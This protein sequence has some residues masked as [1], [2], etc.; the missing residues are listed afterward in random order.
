MEFSERAFFLKAFQGSCLTFVISRGSDLTP[1]ALTVLLQVIREVVTGRAD[2]EG[3]R[4]LLLFEDL[5]AVCQPLESLFL[6]LAPHLSR[7]RV[8]NP[9][10]VPPALWQARERGGLV[11]IG[12]QAE[13]LQQFE[14]NIL[15]F[16]LVLRMSRLVWLD[17]AGG[18][19]DG[20]GRT[21]GFLSRSRLSEKVRE[22]RCGRHRLLQLFQSLLAGG[23]TAISLCRVAELDQELFTYQGMGSFFSCRPYCRVRRLGLDDFEH[24]VALIR[25]GEQE[26]F[27]LP[28]S[29][30]ALA[31]LLA[32]SYG[33]FILEG[34]LAGLCALETVPYQTDRAGEIVSLYT[35]T[36]FQG[37]GI[38]GQLLGHM[39]H[40]AKRQGLRTLFACTRHER[41]AD[42]FLHCRFGRHRLVF[43]R[44]DPDQVPQTKWQSYDP[45]RKKQILCLQLNLGESP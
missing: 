39:V 23:I 38:G 30:E 44:V 42:F 24:A 37:A 40:D 7:L 2:G 16:A 32:G 3:G 29:E 14:E 22:G 6:P 25:K 34:R 31:G 26:G 8:S 20:G 41:V 27:L 36:R 18:I 33:A 5:P 43:R 1:A 9:H 15:A 28:R 19:T 4:V 21:V 11:A 17:G 10:H 12:I 45:I 13:T 35:L